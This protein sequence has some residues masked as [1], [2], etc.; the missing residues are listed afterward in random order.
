MPGTIYKI[1]SIRDRRGNNKLFKSRFI[2]DRADPSQPAV[3]PFRYRTK[4][5]VT[6]RI[7]IVA[8]FPGF[9]DRCCPAVDH[10]SP[11]RIFSTV[12]DCKNF[13][14]DANSESVSNTYFVPKIPVEKCP[15][16]P[17]LIA[18]LNESVAAS[19]SSSGIIS[20]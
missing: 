8:F 15:E 5:R 10:M 6:V 2:I 3:K 13:P 1:K 19:I 9:P 16:G 12:H 20:W 14:G 17:F 11:S 4:H 7:G 18:A